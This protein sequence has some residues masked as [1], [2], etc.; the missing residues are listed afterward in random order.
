MSPLN[1]YKTILRKVS[2]DRQL[3]HKEY[4]KALNELS[5]ADGIRLKKWCIN[6][7][8]MPFHEFVFER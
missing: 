5:N 8:F 4:S 7:Q 3:F 1:Y 6:N 2:F